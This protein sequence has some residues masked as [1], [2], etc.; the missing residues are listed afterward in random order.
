M[1]FLKTFL[2]VHARINEQKAPC[3]LYKVTIDRPQ[4]V[5]RQRKL[6]LKQVGVNL[7]NQFP[8]PWSIIE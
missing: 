1:Y 3:T 6:K 7:I 8:A 5:F 4:G 2:S